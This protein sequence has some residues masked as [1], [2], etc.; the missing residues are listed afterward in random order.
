MNCKHEQGDIYF[1]STDGLG[2]MCGMISIFNEGI[3]D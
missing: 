2:G 3:F 1:S